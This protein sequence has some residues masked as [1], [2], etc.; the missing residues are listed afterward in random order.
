M[1]IR[2]ATPTDETALVELCTAA[3]FDESLFGQTLHPYRH[4]YPDDVKIFWHET[5]RRYFATP[6]F[7]VLVA[8]RTNGNG[9]EKI[10]GMAIWERQGDDEGAKK[11]KEEW[12][13]YG[14]FPPLS[15]TQNRAADP[16]KRNIVDECMLYGAHF[17][18][19][20]RANNWYLSLCGIH[21]DYQGKG[22]GRE[23]VRWGLEKAAQE[24]VPASVVSSD[25]NDAFYLRCGFD[26]IVGDVTAGEGNPML[27]VMGGSVLFKWPEKMS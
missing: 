7:V 15:S 3:F 23:L 14:S 18:S 4:K 27:S 5:I 19:G 21:P 24:G 9:E 13:D 26:E 10:G 11:T 6:G 20:D 8:V 1:P 17:W 12:V 25:G 2:P 22:V 16:T